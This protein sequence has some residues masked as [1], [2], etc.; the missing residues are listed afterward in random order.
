[1]K[2]DIKAETF[3]H[4]LA[5]MGFTRDSS[6]DTALRD[7]LLVAMDEMR[8]QMRIC[9]EQRHAE[10]LAPELP[11]AEFMEKIYKVRPSRGSLQ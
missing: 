1:M 9:M 5:A 10:G 8:A 11:S 6:V 7:S 3:I 2:I 4:C